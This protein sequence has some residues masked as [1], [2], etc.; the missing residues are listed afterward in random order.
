VQLEK[1]YQKKNSPTKHVRE[2]LLLDKKILFLF[3]VRPEKPSHFFVYFHNTS[4]EV[5]G[6]CVMKK[7]PLTWWSCNLYPRARSIQNR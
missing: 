1:T 4:N 2:R 3:D 7:H 6:S 5:A